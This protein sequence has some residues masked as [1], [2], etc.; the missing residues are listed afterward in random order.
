VNE[1][2]RSPLPWRL[3]PFA[4]HVGCR[5]L[6]YVADAKG[7]YITDFALEL[8]DAQRIVASRNAHDELVAALQAA[9]I[10][11]HHCRDFVPTTKLPDGALAAVRAALAKAGAL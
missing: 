2:P 9:E 11:L 7:R 8:D 5:E 6:A 3:V 4:P 10:A 1:F